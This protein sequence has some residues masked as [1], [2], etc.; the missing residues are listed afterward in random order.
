MFNVWPLG[1]GARVRMHVCL[2]KHEY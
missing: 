1:F 2:W